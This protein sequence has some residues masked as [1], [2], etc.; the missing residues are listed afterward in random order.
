MH[1]FEQFRNK[2][3]HLVVELPY[4]YPTINYDNREQWANETFQRNKIMDAVQLDHVGLTKND[5][6]IISDIDEIIDPK[7]LIEFRNGQLLAYKG[8]SLSQDMYYYNLHCKNTWFWSKAKIVTYEYLL[9]KTPEDIRH[10]NLPLLEKGGWH[11]SYFGDVDFIK[12]KING[13]SHQE[14]NNPAYVDNNIIANRLESGVDIFGRNYVQ[15]TNIPIEHNNYL[16]PMYNIYLT[17]YIRSH[18]TQSH[19]SPIYLYYHVCCI[20][21]WKPVMERM[22]FKLKNSGLYSILSEIRCTI[23]GEPSNL[24]DPIFQDSKIKIRFHSSDISL[25]ERQGLNMMIDDANNE[26]DFIVLYMHSKGVRHLGHGDETFQQNVYQ[27]CEYLSYFNIY[28][29]ITMLNELHTGANAI[30]C[31]LQ[32][33]GAPL[34]F[35]GNFWWSK[36]SHI[37]NLPKIV[38]TYYNTPEFWVASI[39]GIYKCIW[40]SHINHYQTS[41]LPE[42]YVNKPIVID[43]ITRTS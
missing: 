40:R 15:M 19:I 6:V 3:I 36:S 39:P 10:T 14:Y 12:T 33:L 5:L 34:H 37:K 13:F 41:Y 20:G 2:I 35:S 16:P 28:N 21:Q 1:L 30:G 22:L 9:Q 25:Y 32:E 11:L 42:Q 27:W 29:H 43:I 26:P 24:S 31:N 23:L 38:D 18:N 8:F 7:R 17:N 4:T